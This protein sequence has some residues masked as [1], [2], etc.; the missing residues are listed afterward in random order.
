PPS[1][2][3]P[4]TGPSG[5]RVD[6]TTATPPA[7]MARAASTTT[8]LALP[9]PVPA[10]TMPRAPAAT[11]ALIKASSAPGYI[12]TRSTRVWSNVD[13]GRGGTVKLVG[14]LIVRVLCC[15]S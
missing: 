7:T 8:G 5:T 11:A 10:T 15:A 14:G 2:Y 9:I 6:N 4:A 13:E 3:T 1:P 12:S